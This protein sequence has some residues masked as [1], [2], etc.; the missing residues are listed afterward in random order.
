ML[1]TAL[2]SSQLHRRYDNSA[3]LEGSEAAV[4]MLIVGPATAGQAGA[5]CPQLD[6]SHLHKISM[7][8]AD[9]RIALGPVL[10]AGGS[11]A[12]HGLYHL[13]I[14]VAGV[15]EP[16]VVPFTFTDASGWTHEKAAAEHSRSEAQKRV[17]ELTATGCHNRGRTQDAQEAVQRVLDVAEA[18]LG[19]VI[20]L[21]DWPQASAYCQNELYRLQQLPA[22]RQL[23]VARSVL[24]PWQKAQLDRIPGVI[25]FAYQ[26]LYV[27]DDD[28]ARLLSW[29]ARS[30]L[31]D[32]FVAAWETKEDV[33]ALWGS[34]GLMNTHS[35]NIVHVPEHSSSRQGALPNSGD[36]H[37]STVPE[38]PCSCV[39]VTCIYLMPL[40]P[41]CIHDHNHIICHM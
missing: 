36:A 13:T 41:C 14:S 26:L 20:G 35:L 31:E 18:R 32:L 34:W 10:V 16:L 8:A 1:S 22:P 11:A 2:K 24:Q 27:A 17:N 6:P 29:F 21:D 5:Q 39:L 15:P 28:Q 30:T 19:S 4:V 33:Q 9:S 37:K 38:L 25:G 12:V 3:Q 7:T 23:R 40:L